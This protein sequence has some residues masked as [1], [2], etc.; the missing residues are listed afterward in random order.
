VS[1]SLSLA[2]VLTAVAAASL[3]AACQ[4]GAAAVSPLPQ[5]GSLAPQSLAGAPLGATRAVADAHHGP[6]KAP[7]T[8]AS[9]SSVHFTAAQAAAGTVQTITIDAK[10]A[11]KLYVSIAG[12]GNCPAVSPSELKPKHANDG[13]HDAHDPKAGVITVTPH[14]AG[15]AICVITVSDRDDVARGHGDAKHD[16]DTKH[17]GDKDHDCDRHDDDTIVIPVT[18]DAPAPVETPS[19]SPTPCTNRL[20]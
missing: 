17:D 5:T 1:H 12:T 15:P 9:P 8:V 20:C 4:G 18:V 11:E 19:P 10:S 3:L 13:G 16:A 6:E 7:D 2:R 14:G